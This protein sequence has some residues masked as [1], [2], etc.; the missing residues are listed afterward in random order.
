MTQFP[1]PD[2]ETIPGE[3]ACDLIMGSSYTA[4]TLKV[5]PNDALGFAAGT[6]VSVEATDATPGSD[7]QTGLLV[8]LSTTETVIELENSLRLHFPRWGFFVRELE[9]AKDA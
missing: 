8:G 4:G 3:K 1:N 9:N 5:D 7:P 2:F 6:P